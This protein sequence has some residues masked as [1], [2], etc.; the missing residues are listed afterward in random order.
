V[1]GYDL[2]WGSRELVDV[3][4]VNVHVEVVGPTDGDGPVLAC[5]HGFASGT[6]TWA[7]MVRALPDRRRV[8]AWDRPPFG[9]SDRPRPRAGAEDPYRLGAELGRTSAVLG[10]FAPDRPLVLVG[11][12]AGSLLAVQV[13][14]ARA[15]P[16]AGLVLIAP[17]VGE[18]PPPAVL[19]AGRLPGAA[20]VARS[21]LRLGSLGTTAFL[22]RTTRHP[23]SL[24]EATAV[25]TG[26]C[27]RRPGTA[28]AL[29]HL[30]STWTS[31]DVISR[32]GDV[33]LPATVIGGADDRIISAAS[34]RAVADGLGAELHLLAGAGHAPHE[35]R[36]EEVARLVERFVGD[37]DG[38]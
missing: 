15:A 10:R 34:H 33:G 7:G 22:R 36:P 20:V 8:L 9:R 3:D 23:T 17:A 29:W 30:A 27:L 19:A 38:R 6:F 11:H 2:R 4:G 25:E 18:G 12:S 13:A 32:L 35:Q 26:R 28:E 14:L 37:L 5:L 31:S 24:T 1:A 21:L 16:V